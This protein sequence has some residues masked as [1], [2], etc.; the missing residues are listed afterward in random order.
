MT[1]QIE[2]SRPESM[3]LVARD[4]VVGYSG[5]ALLPPATFRVAREE[6][7]ALVGPNGSGK[8]TLL[9]TL[10]GL[11]PKIRGDFRWA[12]NI[13]IGYVPQRSELDLSA[14][15]RV[16][17]V[18]AQGLDSSWSFLRPGVVA[19]ER[20]VI[21]KVLD[22]TRM[23]HLFFQPFAALSDGQRQ[24]VLVS[25][26]LAHDPDIL[27]LDEPTNGMDIAAERA[28]FDLFAELKHARKLA[29]VVVSHHMHLLGARAT[30]VV[31]VDKSENHFLAG[32]VATV[33]RDPGFDAHY[34][35]AFH[36][37]P[38]ENGVVHV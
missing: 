1:K 17:D 19:R 23:G 38:P 30:H 21:Q 35:P 10:L 22:E 15:L 31:W 5:R 18:V 7:W 34:G 28:V 2:V 8:T 3:L 11:L 37:T 36:R 27:I 6:L 13:R 33:R 32:D 25:R 9:R 26:A 24:R 4:L 29:L 12:N 20:D 16:C 14:P